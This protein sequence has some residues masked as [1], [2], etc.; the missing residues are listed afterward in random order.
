MSD[1]DSANEAAAEIIDYMAR[2][3]QIEEAVAD[4]LRREPPEPV[5][6]E[7]QSVTIATSATIT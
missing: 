5:V 6:L 4:A 1:N 7:I 3:E 2:D